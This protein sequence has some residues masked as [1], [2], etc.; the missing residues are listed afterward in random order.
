[1][2]GKDK[3]KEKIVLFIIGLLAGS[4]TATGIFY[5]YL[6]TNNCNNKA[7]KNSSNILSRKKEKDNSKH[8]KKT[9][10]ENTKDEQ[11]TEKKEN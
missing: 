10:S 2:K 7:I 8:T 3:L 5:I 1:M 6:T 11:T 9:N 4:I